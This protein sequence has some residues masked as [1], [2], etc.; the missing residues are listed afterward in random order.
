VITR[1]KPAVA[2]RRRHSVRRMA[3]ITLCA[4]LL[5]FVAFS[6]PGLP[7]VAMLPVLLVVVSVGVYWL[8]LAI[9]PQND[10]P[11]PLRLLLIPVLAAAVLVAGVVAQVP[12]KTRFAFSASAFQGTVRDAG[13]PT[14]RSDDLNFSG[15]CPSWIG[16]YAIDSCES[17]GN[18]GVLF[19]DPLGNAMLDY[20][21][22]AYVP[23]GPQRDTSWLQSPQFTHLRGPWYAFVASW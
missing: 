15:S 11:H 21:G 8:I 7:S 14:S 9:S 3:L 20:A 2:R 5:I 4:Y 12:L 1:E 19:F 18:G 13:P 16:L 23:N 10:D 22:F 17:T 6:F